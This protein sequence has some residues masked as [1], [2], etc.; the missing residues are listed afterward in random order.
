LPLFQE[1]NGYILFDFL[2]LKSGAVPRNL[3]RAH[4]TPFNSGFQQPKRQKGSTLS[5]LKTMANVRNLVSYEEALF[6]VII[7][8]YI[9]DCYSIFKRI[10]FAK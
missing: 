4:Q 1:K 3:K 5:F 9:S 2:L 8:P 10:I 6:K 7:T